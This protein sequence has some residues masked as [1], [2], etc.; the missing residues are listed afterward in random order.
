MHINL[1]ITGFASTKDQILLSNEMKRLT[2][3]ESVTIVDS[4]KLLNKDF[5]C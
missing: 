2:Q 3:S 5:D 1:E 4:G